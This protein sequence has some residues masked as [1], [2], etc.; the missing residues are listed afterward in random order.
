VLDPPNW[1]TKNA[2]DDD[3]RTK[4]HTR[5]SLPGRYFSELNNI[6]CIILG[7]GFLAETA[8]AAA[9]SRRPGTPYVS[10]VC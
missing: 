2:H 5:K 10:R 6:S 7:T 1:A 9:V 8:A 4:W 3:A